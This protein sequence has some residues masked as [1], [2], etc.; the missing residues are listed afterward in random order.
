MYVCRMCIQEGSVFNPYMN[1]ICTFFVGKHIE[2]IFL[3]HLGLSK[4]G[5]TDNLGT[6]MRRSKKKMNGNPRKWL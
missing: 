2:D 6:D 3:S 4:I 1:I 5:F